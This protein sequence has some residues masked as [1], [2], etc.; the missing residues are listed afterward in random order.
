MDT[1]LLKASWDNLLSRYGADNIAIEFYSRLFLRAPHLRGLF[2]SDM[3]EQRRKIMAMLNLVIRGAD[4]LDPLVPVLQRLGRDHRRFGA[5]EADFHDVGQALLGTL[6][7]FS[8]EGWTTDVEATWTEAFTAVAGVM[9]QA[10]ADA[11]DQGEP[12]YWDAPVV[13]VERN[14]DRGVIVF[15]PGDGY[16]WRP[17]LLVPLTPHGRPGDWRNIPVEA[18]HDRHLLMRV[19]L[20]TDDLVSL[21]VLQLRQGDTVRL[22]HPVERVEPL[23]AP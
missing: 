9:N 4:N 3:T 18:T 6:A 8:G 20:D 17:G 23:E 11:D 1:D 13:H 7:Y 16:P 10:R 14:G 15:D 2:G 12:V 5:T 19:T 22:G 21:S